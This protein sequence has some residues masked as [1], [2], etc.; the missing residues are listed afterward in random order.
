MTTKQVKLLISGR[1]QG[2]WYR[3]WTVDVAQKLGLAG[4]VRNL[5]TG[6]VEAVVKGEVDKIDVLVK[7]CHEGPEHANV[8]SV[9]ETVDT[10]VLGNEMEFVQIR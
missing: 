6:Q 9:E 8:I 10:S 5:P 1:V 2:V 4:W 7:L 3:R